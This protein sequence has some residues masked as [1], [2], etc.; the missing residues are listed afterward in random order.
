M[1]KMTQLL[2]YRGPDDE[3]YYISSNVGLGHRRLSIIDLSQAGRQP[4][5]NEDG[6]VWAV[7]NGEVYNFQELRD[8]LKKRHHFRSHTDTEVIVHLYEE[9]GGEVFKKIDGMFAIAIYD[10][11]KNKLLLA[12]DRLGK[13]PLY[14]GKYG[15]TLI[16]GSELKALIAHPLFKKELNIKS[17]NKYLLYEYVPT[18]HTIF[19]D[20]HKLEPGFYLEFDGGGEI[21]KN[22]FWDIKFG[23]ENFTAKGDIRKLMRKLDVKLDNAVKKRLVSDV[24]LGVFLSGGIDSSAIA[25]YAQKNSEQKI[26]T[27]SIGFKEDSFDESKYARMAAKHLGTEHYEEIL[28]ASDSLDIIPKIAGLLDEPL[29]DASII[30]TFLLSKFTKRNVTVALGGDGGD[31]LFCGYGTFI[32]SRL[33]DYY[34][35]TPAFIRNNLI[36][37]IF[38]KM[39]VS[40]KNFSIDFMAKKFIAGLK[41][42]K[43]YRNHEWLGSF[44]KSERANLFKQDVWRELEKDNEFEDIDDYLLNLNSADYYN[45]IIYLYLRMYMMDGVLVKVDRASMYNSLEVRTPFLDTDVVDFANSLPLKLKLCGLTTKYI[46][47]KLMEDKLPKEIVHRPKKGFGVPMAEWLSNELKPLALDLLS[48]ERIKKEGL[49]NYDYIKKILEDHFSKRKD[50]RKL[51]WTLMVFQ[52]W[53]EKFL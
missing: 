33:V 27:F 49:F 20:I 7:F 2:R 10:E 47:K 50:N 1:E 6:S 53:Q 4:M 12:R 46:L 25:Y 48:E 35:R 34:E 23:T 17:L 37:K 31:E 8:E 40:F 45:Q 22:K 26:K 36:E 11:R 24:P 38:L 9:V 14:W 39:P 3:G 28:S 51:I 32:A 30:P 21:K 43:K 19:K 13:K 42:E 29:A 15:D 52:N 16:F 18:P 44:N 5:S 41:A